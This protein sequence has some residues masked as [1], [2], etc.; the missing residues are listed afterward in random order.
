MGPFVINDNGAAKTYTKDPRGPSIHIFTENL[1]YAINHPESI[2]RAPRLTEAE[3]ERCRVYNAKYI[4][5]D[6]NAYLGIP[7]V[8]LW[9]NM[10]ERDVNGDYNSDGFI[11]GVDADYFPSVKPGDCICV[12]E[13]T[14]HDS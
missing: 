4:T 14:S 6:L 5:R 13:V 10:P 11:A 8:Y 3:L 9:K 2:I 7:R 12:E 1:Q